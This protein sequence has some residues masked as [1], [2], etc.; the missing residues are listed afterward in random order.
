MIIGIGT[1]SNH[2]RTPLPKPIFVASISVRHRKAE[3][4]KKFLHS[5]AF[6]PDERYV[7]SNSRRRSL[8]HSSDTGETRCGAASTGERYLMR[9]IPSRSVCRPASRVSSKHQIGIEKAPRRDARGFE[10]T[11]NRGVWGARPGAS[12]LPIRLPAICS[13]A[14]NPIQ[15]TVRR[16]RC[17]LSE[18]TFFRRLSTHDR[19]R[20]VHPANKKR[21]G[22]V[23][24]QGRDGVNSREGNT[25]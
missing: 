2:R 5:G 10:R 22:D 13:A 9:I 4:Q 18:R 1:P 24:R 14:A 8:S 15:M 11:L 20:G 12:I 7:T 17:W 16:V 6:W 3:R 23:K 21:G 19:D 25:Y